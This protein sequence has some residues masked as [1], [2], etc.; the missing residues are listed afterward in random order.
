VHTAFIPR[1]VRYQRGPT[2]GQEDVLRPIFLSLAVRTNP[3]WS[4]LP[5]GRHPRAMTFGMSVP[6]RADFRRIRVNSP[7]RGALRSSS[8]RGTTRR[9]EDSRLGCQCYWQ[10][11]F[12]CLQ[13]TCAFEPLPC[14]PRCL[15]RTPL[16]ARFIHRE[17][18]SAIARKVNPPPDPSKL[19][20]LVTC[21]RF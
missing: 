20:L 4:I 12:V 17:S 19:A 10:K 6:W 15:I 11:K 2:R 7:Q 16:S 14:R 13:A 9:R 1:G 21:A 8:L 3:E 18:S 5:D